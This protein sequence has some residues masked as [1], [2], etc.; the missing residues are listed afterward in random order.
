M[1]EVYFF[2]I[3]IYRLDPTRF[4]EET[5]RERARYVSGAISEMSNAAAE[6]VRPQVERD[7][8]KRKS[9]DWRFNDVI[10][11]VRLYVLGTQI[12]GELHWLRAKRIGRHVSDRIYFESGKLFE[13][14]VDLRWSSQK[15]LQTIKRRLKEI[16][17]SGKIRGRFVDLETFNAIAPHVNWKALVRS[18]AIL[19]QAGMGSSGVGHS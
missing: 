1:P 16:S 15:L 3:P 19:G 2:D 11:W 17:S 4:A 18:G 5:E 13:G 14:S 6:L 10:G 12:R 9:H 7:Y 8:D